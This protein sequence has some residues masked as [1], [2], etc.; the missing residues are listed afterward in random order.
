MRTGM[1]ALAVSL[2]LGACAHRDSYVLLPDQSG[3]APGALTIKPVDAAAQSV[4]LDQAYQ[5]ASSTMGGGFDAGKTDAEDVQRRYGAALDAVPP[6]VVRFT[7]YFL[8]GSDEL[9]P[10]SKAD[11]TAV[12]GEIKGRPVPDI[13]VVGHTDR[14]GQIADNDR[15]ALRRAEAFRK[16]LLE[17][18]IPAD[19]I[20]TA[21]R[22]EREPLI[23]TADETP[24][25][26]NRRVEVLVR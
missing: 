10:K 9:T 14:V 8:E 23:S 26:R 11:L 21:G 12:L 24:E 5:T 18:G 7:L 13:V 20:Q 1:I 16:K 3:Q 17:Q 19:A 4:K 15:L 6:P 2:T 22:G 25:P